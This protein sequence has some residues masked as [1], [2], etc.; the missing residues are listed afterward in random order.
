MSNVRSSRRRQ[1]ARRWWVNVVAGVLVLWA[2]VATTRLVR[3]AQQIHQGTAAVGRA[4]G[5][6]DAADI[7]ARRPV[8]PIDAAARAFARAHALTSGAVMAPLRYLPV[9]GRQ[10]RSV[11]A[12]S[13]S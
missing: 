4:R 3:A 5:L 8:A 13:G 6:F 9:A 12:L 7:E 11:E 10:I 1:Q 2:G